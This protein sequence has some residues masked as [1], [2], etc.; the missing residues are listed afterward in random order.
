MNSLGLVLAAAIVTRLAP[1]PGVEG[2][3]RFAAER[4]VHIRVSFAAKEFAPLCIC[5]FEVFETLTNGCIF[6]S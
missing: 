4:R 1:A 5:G 2:C 6:R 3:C